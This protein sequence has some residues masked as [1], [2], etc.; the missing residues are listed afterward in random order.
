MF[1]NCLLQSL[2]DTLALELQDYIIAMASKE[3][4][5]QKSLKNFNLRQEI[6]TYHKIKS[7]WR[8]IRTCTMQLFKMQFKVL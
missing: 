8:L 7:Q 2:W 3:D 5:L 1:F 6:K 4:R